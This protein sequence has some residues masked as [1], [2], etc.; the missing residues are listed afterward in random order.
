M[1]EIL[2]QEKNVLI[3]MVIIVKFVECHLKRHTAK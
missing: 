1:K 3:N 2:P